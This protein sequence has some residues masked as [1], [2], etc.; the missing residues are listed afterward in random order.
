MIAWRVTIQIE[1]VKLIEQE[2]EST[3]KSQKDFSQFLNSTIDIMNL[4]YDGGSMRSFVV[5]TYAL[6]LT[7]NQIE[8][9][10][11][12]IKEIKS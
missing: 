7:I 1:Y 12:M 9:M 5:N 3:K 2:L 11:I 6:K 8:L 4:E 10:R